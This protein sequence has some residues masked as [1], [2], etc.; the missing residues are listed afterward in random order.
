MTLAMTLGMS[1]GVRKTMWMMWGELLGVATVAIT[2][3]V[4]VSA[5][6]LKY[7]LIFSFLKIAG[8]LYLLWIGVN[9]WRSKGKLALSDSPSE[10][11]RISK[12]TLFN[13]GFLTAIANPKGWA[14]M[15]SLLPPFINPHLSLL[16]QLTV[17]VVVISCSEFICMMLYATGGK[18]IGKA[19]TQQNNVK[20]LNKIS[21]SLMIAVAIWLALS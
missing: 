19:L 11:T 9:M 7:P 2:A 21:G 13:Q 16:G 14:F 8:A 18:T 12:L 20:K 5:V 1:I 17:L 6:M 10:S 4:G 3:V 15:I